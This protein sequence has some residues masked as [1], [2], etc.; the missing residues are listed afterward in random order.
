MELRQ[1]EYFVAVAE[2]ANFTR[3]AERVHISQSGISA[4]IRQLERELGSELFDRSSRVARLTVAGEAALTHAKAALAAA[5]AAAEAVGDVTGVV[6]GRLRVGMVSGCTMTR[7]FESL[8]SFHNDHPGVALTV[9]E[10]SSDQLVEAVRLGLLDMALVGVPVAPP[11]DLS[12][13][14]VVSEGLAVLVPESH[15][16]A[17]AASVTVLD[18][19]DVPLICMP[20]GTG[21]RAVLDLAFAERGV[22]VSTTVHASAPSAIADLA[23]RGLGAAVLSESMASIAPDLSAIPLH[24][25][26][27]RAVLAL[28]WPAVPGPALRMLIRHCHEAFGVSEFGSVASTRIATDE[29][30][31]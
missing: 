5:R 4:Q 1:L 30:T 24:G 26:D 14:I 17:S 9:T 29:P 12:S 15:P 23:R 28:T 8:A 31:G 21:I 2:E 18:L 10:G 6:R 19:V 25:T 3:A 27:L 20:T 7:L 22:R 11:S 16:L 13:L